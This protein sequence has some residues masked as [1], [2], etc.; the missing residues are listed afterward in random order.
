MCH[1]LINATAVTHRPSG[2]RNY[3][4][5]QAS[6]TGGIQWNSNTL[7]GQSLSW[8]HR[9][10]LSDPMQLWDGGRVFSQTRLS[11][12]DAS[13]SAWFARAQERFSPLRHRILTRPPIRRFGTRPIKASHFKEQLIFWLWTRPHGTNATPPIGTVGNRCTCRRI[14]PI[15]IL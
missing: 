11:A 8:R 15:L 6:F 14:R 13:T 3:W 2:K 1:I 10:D 4:R 5:T 7:D 9:W 12:K